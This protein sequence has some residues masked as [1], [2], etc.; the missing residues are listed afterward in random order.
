MSVE[1]IVIPAPMAKTLL[2]ILKNKEILPT[3]AVEELLENPDIVAYLT[4][5]SNPETKEIYASVWDLE[6]IKSMAESEGCY[7]GELPDEI[8]RK[9]LVHAINTHDLGVGINWDSLQCDLE[10][11][12]AEE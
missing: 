2:R 1:D 6:D 11:V 5:E 7:D 10:A 12:N 8:A 9:T 3:L 4:R